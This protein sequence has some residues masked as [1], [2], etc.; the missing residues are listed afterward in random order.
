MDPTFT[1]NTPSVSRM[2]A[3][4]TILLIDEEEYILKFM[5]I[6][7]RARGYQVLMT[8]DSFR[9]LEVAMS[10]A[11][12]L[13]VTDLMMPRLDGITLI[14]RLHAFSNLP[15]IVVSG[16]ESDAVRIDALEN[17]AAD[18]FPKPFDLERLVECIAAG[19]PAAA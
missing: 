10:G 7:L 9:G 14:K 2:V 8:A 16:C 5:G 6:L 15:V 3:P 19:L 12:D 17:G 18:Y 13:V 11:A 4:R 1:E